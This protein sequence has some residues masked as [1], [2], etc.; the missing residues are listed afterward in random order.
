M[1][2]Q[3]SREVAF[4]S[5]S[6]HLGYYISKRGHGGP[7]WVVLSTVAFARRMRRRH[8]RPPPFVNTRTRQ[9]KKRKCLFAFLNSFFFF[10][11]ASE[12]EFIPQDL[13]SPL[14]S[15]GVSDYYPGRQCCHLAAGYSD[16]FF[17]VVRPPLFALYFSQKGK[18]KRAR[19][20]RERGRQSRI[21][22]GRRMLA[23]DEGENKYRENTNKDPW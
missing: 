16:S 13:T 18:Q 12:G 10:Q 11:F 2:R 7:D 5:Q 14:F 19:R 20:E 22:A 3:V 21:R 8:M 9:M 23:S 4:L 1:T 17:C 15:A 6:P